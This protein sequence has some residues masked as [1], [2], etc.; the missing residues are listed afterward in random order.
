MKEF[1]NTQRMRNLFSLE[2]FFL[3]FKKHT[4]TQTINGIRWSLPLLTTLSD[5]KKNKNHFALDFCFLIEYYT[6]YIQ[7]IYINMAK[8]II[9]EGKIERNLSISCVQY[10]YKYNK[11]KFIKKKLYTWKFL[12]CLCVCV[13]SKKPTQ[14]EYSYGW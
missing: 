12:F 14:T 13:C 3:C 9:F 4:H 5:G 10:T 2:N 1:N 8:N 7:N 6:Y 11:D